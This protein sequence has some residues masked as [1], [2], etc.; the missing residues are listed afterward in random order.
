MNTT[1]S[2]Y[3]Q[4]GYATRMDYLKCLAED[5]GMEVLDVVALADILGPSEDFDGLVSALD[6]LFYSEE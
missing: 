3:T 6:D 2:V 5:Y 1:E 4:N